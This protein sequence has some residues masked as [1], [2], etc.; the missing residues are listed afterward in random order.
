[1]LKNSR[2]L[3]LPS[4]VLVAFF[5]LPK[6]EVNAT[7]KN[8]TSLFDGLSIFDTTDKVSSLKLRKI[9][10]TAQRY[11]AAVDVFRTRF[12]EYP[13]DIKTASM[14]GLN[15]GNGNGDGKITGNETI[16]FWKHLVESNIIMN[17]QTGKTK[18][19]NNS[20][21]VVGFDVPEI[22]G[23][24][25][26]GYFVGYYTDGEHSGNGIALAT[27]LPDGNLSGAF[28]PKEAKAINPAPDKHVITIN[29]PNSKDC[30]ADS[31]Y[32]LASNKKSCILIYWIN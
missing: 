7:Q 22:D 14:F 4:I 16:M 24:D 17:F 25:N 10:S 29:E 31:Q 19:P 1:M 12:N 18:S 15:G 23:R 2:L 26:V 30:I 3:I 6:P 27:K 11:V 8:T 28:T 9:K 20:D 21:I 5:S 32:N 13:G